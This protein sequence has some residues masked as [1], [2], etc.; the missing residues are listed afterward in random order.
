MVLKPAEFTP[1]TSIALAE[2]AMRAGIPKGILSVVF[3]DAVAIGNTLTD[4]DLVRKITFTGST[5]VGI[6]LTQN[7]AKTVKKVSMELGG[8]APFIVFD[9]KNSVFQCNIQFI[10]RSSIYNFLLIYISNSRKSVWRW[11]E[12]RRM[13]FL[14]VSIANFNI[15]SNL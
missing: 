3:G 1:L 8:N 6:L 5:K 12:M 9:G 7:S 10:L 15:K 11:G 14:M 13:L 2:L 4:S